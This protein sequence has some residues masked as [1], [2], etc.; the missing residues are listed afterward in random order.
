MTVHQKHAVDFPTMDVGAPDILSDSKAAA[1]P[2]RVAVA[3]CMLAGMC[4]FLNV[5]DTQPL[6]PYLQQVFRASEIAVSL[7]VS[8]TILAMA[9]TAPI[10]GLLAESI[11][12]KKVIV[13][14]LYAVTVPTLL[15]ATSRSLHQLIFWRFMQGVFV[16]GVIV[17]MMAYI[18]EEFPRQ[19]VGRAMSAYIAGTVLGGFLGR[20]ISGI[21]AHNF[22]WREAFLAIGLVNLAGAILVQQSLPRAKNFVPAHS[23]AHSISEGWQHMHNPRLLAV[24]GMGF[25]ALF[26]L[27]GTFTYANF[28]LAAPPY[29]L[30]PAQLG[31]VFFVY[32]FGFV[33][34]P[35]SGRTLDHYGVNVTSVIAF[36]FAAVGL[37]LTLVHSLAVIIAGLALASSGVFIYQAVGTVQTGLVAEKARSSAAGLYVTFYY[38]GGSLGAVVTGWTW[39]AGGWPACVFLLTGV[40][41]LA[42]LMALVS[43]RKGAV[44]DQSSAIGATFVE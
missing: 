8:A 44:T 11:G 1:A 40:A 28:Y 32:L 25:T 5:Y 42:L 20:Y 30:N 15:A 12:R 36:A 31:S 27:V 21:V 4:T 23:V 29:Y 22:A 41:G 26:C 33:V 43:S 7:T 18:N 37:L 35:L 3:A 9:L 2:S 6:L 10:I 16:P 14:S 19:Q 24:F 39:I 13:P 38:I 34:T 17:V